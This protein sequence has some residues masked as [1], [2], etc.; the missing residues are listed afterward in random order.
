MEVENYCEGAKLWG[1]RSRFD[2]FLARRV[3]MD[4]QITVE[5]TFENGAKRTRCLGL[6]SQPSLA[7]DPAAFRPRLEDASSTLGKFDKVVLTDQV[8]EF[9]EA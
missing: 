9:Y 7:G 6:L 5:I 2:V 1:M 3:G 8:A 4:I